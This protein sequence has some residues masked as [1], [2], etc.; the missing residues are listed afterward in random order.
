M[1]T[2]VPPRD[3]G[4]LPFQVAVELARLAPKI[5]THSPGWIVATVLSAGTIPPDLIDGA[6][7]PDGVIV[8]RS[9]AD[10][11][12]APPPEIVTWLLTLAGAFEATLTITVM[13]E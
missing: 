8:V 6:G 13:A 9:L 7:A 5:D 10:C 4:K 12:D 11:W 3:V 1:V 2:L